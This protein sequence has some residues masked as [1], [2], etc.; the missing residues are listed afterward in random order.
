MNSKNVAIALVCMLLVVGGVAVWRISQEAPA[1]TTGSAAPPESERLN[2][3]PPAPFKSETPGSIAAEP[4]PGAVPETPGIPAEPEVLTAETLAGTSWE[5]DMVSVRFLPDG[6][7]EMNGRI[8]AKWK[9][10]GS[11]VRIYDDKGEEYLVDIVGN[12]LEF[13]GKKIARAAD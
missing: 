4:E 9:V 3:G 13:N 10:E 7:W 12:S 2:P 6:R 1:Q 5:D 11:R 8:C